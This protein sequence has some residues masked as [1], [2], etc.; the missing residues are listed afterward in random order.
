[1]WSYFTKQDIA[2]LKLWVRP[3]QGARVPTYGHTPSQVLWEALGSLSHPWFWP[4][5]IL[6]VNRGCLKG[7]EQAWKSQSILGPINADTISRL[8][9]RAGL[10]WQLCLWEME[11]LGIARA[12]PHQEPPS[13]DVQKAHTSGCSSCSQLSW[14]AWWDHV[15][16]WAGIWD[17]RREGADQ[18]RGES[19]TSLVPAQQAP[20]RRQPSSTP[21][22]L[23]PGIFVSVSIGIYLCF[24]LTVLHVV[25][26]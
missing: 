12:F 3:K 2:G 14:E 4:W 15:A 20:W 1:M 25:E 17:G 13:P 16:G 26:S 10:C 21:S 7:L 18:L 22:S 8:F 11:R 9:A 6:C 24:P 5:G 23:P 19:Q